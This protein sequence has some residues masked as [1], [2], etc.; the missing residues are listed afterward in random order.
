[1]LTD[2]R[3]KHDIFLEWIKTNPTIR[4]HD[5]WIQEYVNL[6]NFYFKHEWYLIPIAYRDKKPLANY[7]WD[8]KRLTYEDAFKYVEQDLNMAVVLEYSELIAVDW[9]NRQLHKLL[10]PFLSKTLSAIT[11]RGYH[12]Y[13]K[14]TDEKD[15]V[16]DKMRTLVNGKGDMFRGGI[17]YC[18]LPISIVAQLCS[19]GHKLNPTDK[20]CNKCGKKVFTYRSPKVYEWLNLVEPISFTEFKKE[21]LG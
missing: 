20:F 11:P 3:T 19:C 1:M 18:L 8:K 16:Y 2:S 4:F 5:W 7:S 15:T 14:A 9:D 6:L 12:I 10:I 13:F 17:Q 21:L